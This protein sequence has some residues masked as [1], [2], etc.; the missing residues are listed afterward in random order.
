MPRKT[1][2]NKMNEFTKFYIQP[3]FGTDIV[4]FD[5]TPAEV[6]Q[7]LG[8]AENQSTNHQGKLVEFR[9]YMNVAYSSEKRV[10]HIGFGRQ[11]QEVYLGKINIFFDDPKVVLT[12]LIGLDSEVFLYLGFLFFFK[13]GF[14]LTGFHDGDEDQKALALF[15]QG[16]WNSR[17]SKM[18][19]FVLS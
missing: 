19:P 18:K 9:S 1:R 2:S 7:A 10:D 17:K 5:M 12:E 16:H 13:L 6:V 4:K 11:M 15:T 3:Y 8:V 14:S